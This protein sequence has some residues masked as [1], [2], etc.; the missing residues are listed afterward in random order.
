MQIIS[1]LSLWLAAAIAAVEALGRFH[2]PV[3]WGTTTFDGALALVAAICLFHGLARIRRRGT[4]GAMRLGP[5][6]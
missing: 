2:Y 4:M 1:T 5:S 6:H 3:T